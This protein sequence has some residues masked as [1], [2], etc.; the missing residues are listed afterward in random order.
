[1]TAQTVYFMTTANTL[2]DPDNA[3]IFFP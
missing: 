2:T 3:V 1:V